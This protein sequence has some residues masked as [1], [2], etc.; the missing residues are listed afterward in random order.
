VR[1]GETA[2]RENRMPLI[3]IRHALAYDEVRRVRDSLQIVAAN[4]LSCPD[5]RLTP[6]HIMIAVDEQGPD[7]SI[8]K[9][10]LVIVR[11]HNFPAR[12]QNHAN[13]CRALDADVSGNLSFGRTWGVWVELNPMEYLSDTER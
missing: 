9:D 10:I 12:V 1:A 6:A 4:E 7:D 5:R 3:Q 8:P 13:I 11:A 2:T